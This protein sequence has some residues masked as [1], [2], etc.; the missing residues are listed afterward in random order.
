[1]TA[2]LPR[3]FDEGTHPRFWNGG[4]P[5]RTIVLDAFSLM[6]PA[7]EAFMIRAMQGAHDRIE[8]P[9]LRCEVANFVRQEASHA[10]VHAQYNRAMQ[11]RGFD[12]L[13]QEA[14]VGEAIAHLDG[15]IGTRRRMAASAGLEHFTALIADLLVHEPALL[16][17]ADERY[18]NLWVWHAEEELEHKCVAFDVHAALFPRDAWVSRARAMVTSIVLLTV[19]FWWN[20]AALMR[21]IRRSDRFFVWCGIVWYVFGAPGL[22]RRVFLRTLGFF[23]PGFHPAENGAHTGGVTAHA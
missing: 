3:A 15:K 4:S 11:A 13:A 1:M 19:L 20:A 8:D 23:R 9:A 7:A 22:F 17:G 5:A 18:R 10:R 21:G 2:Q 14:R 6:F 12:A 16:R